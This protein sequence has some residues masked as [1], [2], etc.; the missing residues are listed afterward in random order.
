MPELPADPHAHSWGNELERLLKKRGG[1]FGARV[2]TLMKERH[3]VAAFARFDPDGDGQIP[4]THIE[5]VVR[6]TGTVLRP[7]EIATL[8]EKMDKDRSGT[9]DMWELCCFLVKRH[10][11][12]ADGFDE[13]KWVDEALN[14]V[15]EADEAG[16]VTVEEL[17]RVFTMTDE[18]TLAGVGDA[19]FQLMLAELGLS[20]QGDDAAV[21]LDALRRHPAFSPAAQPPYRE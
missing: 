13:G 16:K 12:V 15:L 6:S 14:V 3:V 21:S 4:T 10:D 1:E 20:G 17:R 7:N 5:A 18:C 8:E 9:V 19:S 2:A 11:E